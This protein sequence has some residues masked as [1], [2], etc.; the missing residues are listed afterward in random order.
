MADTNLP[1]TAL[2]IE[3]AALVLAKELDARCGWRILHST[4]IAIVEKMLWESRNG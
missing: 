3:S 1:P 4:A 2:E